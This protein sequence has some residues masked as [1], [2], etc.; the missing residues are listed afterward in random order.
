MH[1]CDIQILCYSSPWNKRWCHGRFGVNIHLICMIQA[2]GMSLCVTFMNPEYPKQISVLKINVMN[3]LF[4]LDLYTLTWPWSRTEIEMSPTR[5]GLNW[6]SSCTKSQHIKRKHKYPVS[7]SNFL[8][9]T[10]NPVCCNQF[11]KGIYFFSIFFFI[12]AAAAAAAEDEFSKLMVARC[13]PD[14]CPLHQ[15]LMTGLWRGKK[16]QTGL[17][18]Q[19]AEVWWGVRAERNDCRHA[20]DIHL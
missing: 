19:R 3:Y 10:C 13:L 16:A 14:A 9:N 5:E 12:A 2:I 6:V 11:K 18:K 17:Y 4:L 1:S 7:L 8:E 15:I 20:P